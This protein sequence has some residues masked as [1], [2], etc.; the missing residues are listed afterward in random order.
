MKKNLRYY[1]DEDG[2]NQVTLAFTE[3]PEDELCDFCSMLKPP[4]KEYPCKDFE[5]PRVWTISR[6]G[7]NACLKCAELIDANDREGLASRSALMLSFNMGDPPDEIYQEMRELHDLFFA[8]RIMPQ[9]QSAP[10]EP[11]SDRPE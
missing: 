11:K 10:P 2:R 7:W 4:Y 3:K 1:T 8:N 9:P 6:N 5:I